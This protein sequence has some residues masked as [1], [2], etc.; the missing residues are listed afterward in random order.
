MPFG[1]AGNIESSSFLNIRIY[2]YIV[3][4]HIGVCTYV[5]TYVRTYACMYVYIYI[6]ACTHK[7]ISCQVRKFDSTPARPPFV[8]LNYDGGRRFEG[9]AGKKPLLPGT[10]GSK[11]LIRGLSGDGRIY[12]Y[13]SLSIYIYIYMYIGS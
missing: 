10:P 12:I 4:I 7:L 1:L 6:Y 8:A 9:G 5:R 2:I 11:L 3:Y 13:I